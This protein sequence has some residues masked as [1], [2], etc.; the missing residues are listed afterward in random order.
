ML[1]LS[2][3]LAAPTTQSLT[4]TLSSAHGD[5]S[6]GAQTPTST[7]TLTASSLSALNEEL[8]AV[9]YTGTGG[10]DVL[11]I[12][13]G[14]GIL[15]GLQSLIGINSGSS[16][17]VD[18]YSGL[19]FTEAELVSFGSIGE[20]Y[21]DTTAHA[22]GGL[23]VTGQVEYDDELL[24]SGYSGTALQ[25]DDG[26]NAVF[27]A[28]ASVSLSGNVTIGD[29]NGAGALEVL[30]NAAS[31]NGNLTLAAGG[32]GSGSSLAVLGALSVS[33][34]ALVGASGNSHL[35]RIR[36]P[37]RWLVLASAPGARWRPMTAPPRL[38]AR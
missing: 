13:S 24:A 3:V 22:L 37:G 17:T 26:G 9:S 5:L 27:G 10:P 14:T 36:Q 8:A 21:V 6:T 38:W 31:L 29:T 15:A 19:G 35:V 32:A 33:G 34:A 4:L 2:L 20:L 18:G 16:G 25:I 1:G 12:S 30:T 7:L 28:A 23:L 11:T